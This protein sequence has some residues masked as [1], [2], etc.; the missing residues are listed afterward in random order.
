MNCDYC[1]KHPSECVCQVDDQ[2]GF[3]YLEDNAIQTITRS[4][5]MEHREEGLELF[6]QQFSSYLAGAGMAAPSVSE[7][8][9]WAITVLEHAPLY[10]WV[11]P[12]SSSGKYHPPFS[13][14][15]GG[16]VRHTFAVM[17]LAHEFSGTFELKPF[18]KA[19]AVTAAAIH[20]MCKYGL[21]YDPM[22]FGVH[23]CLVRVKIGPKGEKLSHLLHQEVLETILSAVESHN[24]SFVSGSW[25]AFRRPPEGPISQVLHLADYAASRKK[26]NIEF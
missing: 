7:L 24:G 10:F 25:T 21:S 17:Y 8:Y 23:E 20:D 16:L 1:K 5:A 9:N 14:G 22:Y 11:I 26:V 2:T 3:T 13:Q 15:L 18:E 4:N 6:K 12:S 19:V